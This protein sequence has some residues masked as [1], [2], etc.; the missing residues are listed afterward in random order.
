MGIAVSLLGLN[1]VPWLA[2]ASVDVTIIGGSLQHNGRHD[3]LRYTVLATG[4]GLNSLLGLI[5][6][7]DARKTIRGTDFYCW[8]FE[9]H[10]DS[11]VLFRILVMEPKVSCWL[12]S[13]REG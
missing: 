8:F 2:P 7:R 1:I 10:A 11:L 3:E 9:K 6:A 5:R 4:P 12:I 13:S